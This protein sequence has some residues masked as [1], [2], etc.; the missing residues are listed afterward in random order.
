MSAAQGNECIVSDFDPETLVRLLCGI[1]E[2]PEGAVAKTR[3][4]KPR[5]FMDTNERWALLLDDPGAHHNHVR[6]MRRW[7][8]LQCH[9]FLWEKCARAGRE[10]GGRAPESRQCLASRRSGGRCGNWATESIGVCHRHQSHNDVTPV[11]I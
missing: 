7:I 4:K 3:F 2:P 5:R 1:R 11:I 10:L 6:R 8:K 9:W